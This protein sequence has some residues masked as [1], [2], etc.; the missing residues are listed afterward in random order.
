MFIVAQP[1]GV[2]ELRLLSPAELQ[3]C[4]LASVGLKNTEIA[5]RRRSPPKTVARQLRT[6]YRK[7]GIQNRRQLAR[8]FWDD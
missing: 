5:A 7:L 4:V 6:A 3:V 1:S 8:W 2:A